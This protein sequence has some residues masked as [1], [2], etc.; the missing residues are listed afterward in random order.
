V[1]PAASE[2]PLCGGNCIP[3]SGTLESLPGPSMEVGEV[4]RYIL[5]PG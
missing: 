1:G 4:F 3:G 5:K 2:V